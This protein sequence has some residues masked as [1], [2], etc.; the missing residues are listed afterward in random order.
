MGPVHAAGRWK[1]GRT[2]PRFAVFAVEDVSSEG[3][4]SEGRCVP[5]L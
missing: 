5:A 1:V 4:V 3:M 2:A